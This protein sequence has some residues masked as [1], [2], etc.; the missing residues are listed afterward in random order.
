[1]EIF[2]DG[3]NSNFATLDTT[4]TNAEVVGTGGQYVITANNA[5]REAEAGN[6]GFGE[7]KAWFAKTDWTDTGY[8]AEFRISMS[9]IG[10]PQAGEIIGFSVA[11]N[12]CDTDG[13]RQV[14]WCGTAHTEATYGNLYLGPK[15]Y[16]APKVTTSPTID[17]VINA[18]EYANASTISVDNH[19]GYYDLESGDD[20]W[21]NGDNAYEAWVVHDENAIY[22]AVDVTDDVIVTDTAS[23][24]SEDGSTWEDDAVE[25]FF[26]ANN[27]KNTTYTNSSLTDHPAFE[28]Q[29]VITPNNAWRDNEAGNPLYGESDDWYALT[30]QTGA[31]YRAEFKITKSALLDPVDGTIMGFTIGLD[32]D[33][34]S[35]RKLQLLWQGRAHYE[36]SYG[37]L[38]LSSEGTAVPEWSLF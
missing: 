1:M 13:T 11:V 24:G 29:Y 10:N 14:I 27:D 19:T 26:D 22:V 34:G 35:G 4:G 18:S 7:D 25:I 12:D 15:S 16:T 31:G 17:S 23:E 28:G 37:S 30:T 38:T 5:Y 36:P 2:V 33:D 6:P 8:V 20:T 9:T 32:D 3:D 21:E